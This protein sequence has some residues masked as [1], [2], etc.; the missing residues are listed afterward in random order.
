MCS[1]FPTLHKLY[2]CFLSVLTIVPFF[3]LILDCLPFWRDVIRGS[4][5]LLIFLLFAGTEV[6]TKASGAMT[7]CRDVIAPHTG[8]LYG[9]PHNTEDGVVARDDGYVSRVDVATDRTD[10]AVAWV[11]GDVARDDVTVI[12]AYVSADV[13][14]KLVA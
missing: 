3:I 10:V 8:P 11:D 1:K 13:A 7:A 4:I 2:S 5:S 14:P 6:S 12:M 9:G